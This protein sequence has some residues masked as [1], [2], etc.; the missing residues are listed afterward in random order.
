MY[1]L[2][3][4][5]K[6]LTDEYCRKYINYEDRENEYVTYA[7]NDGDMLIKEHFA[8]GCRRILTISIISRV[9]KK[10]ENIYDLIEV[11]DLVKR[12]GIILEV[13]EIQTFDDE[14]EKEFIFDSFLNSCCESDIQAIYKPNSK[15]DYIKVWEKK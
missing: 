12:D 4:S 13:T 11:G 8:N 10:S 6:I 1:Y 14:T 9:I 15:G 2:L 7:G 5:K 3:E